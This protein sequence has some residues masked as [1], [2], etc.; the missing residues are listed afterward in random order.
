MNFRVGYIIFLGS[1][2]ATEPSS[3]DCGITEKD[4][5][6]FQMQDTNSLITAPASKRF[7]TSSPETSNKESKSNIVS[8]DFNASMLKDYES[9]LKSNIDYYEKNS[10]LETINSCESEDPYDLSFYKN[11][12]N[13]RSAYDANFDFDSLEINSVP[14]TRFGSSTGDSIRN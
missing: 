6:T 2:M 9:K 10:I 12:F 3:K 14:S 8:Y 7:K 1:I 13:R 4:K 11:K 5:A